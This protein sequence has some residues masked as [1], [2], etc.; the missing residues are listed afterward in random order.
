M[1]PLRPSL[2]ESKPSSIQPNQVAQ[3]S[4]C[5]DTAPANRADEAGVLTVLS[6]MFP[7]ASFVRAIW[8]GLQ[9]KAAVGNGRKREGGIWDGY[10]GGWRSAPSL[11]K[12]RARSPLYRTPRGRDDRRQSGALLSGNELLNSGDAFEEYWIATD[13]GNG[14]PHLSEF[15]A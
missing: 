11:R 3:K 5:G 12:W 8:R 14:R 1:N 10:G 2:L 9:G 6:A 15:R 13:G 7:L 4:F